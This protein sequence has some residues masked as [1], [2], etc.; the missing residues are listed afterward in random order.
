MLAYYISG[1][2]SFTI[3]TQPNV[4]CVSI[5]PSGSQALTLHLQNMYT[6]VNTSGSISYTYQPYESTLNFTASISSASVGDEY[7]AYITNGDAPIW[8]GSINVF[9]SQSIDKVNYK[10]QIPLENLYVSN[11]SDNEYIILE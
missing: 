10:N 7:R 5:A 2:N 11:I 6:L 4:D 3:R 9:T 1:S 8:H